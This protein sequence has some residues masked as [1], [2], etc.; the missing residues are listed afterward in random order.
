MHIPPLLLRKGETLLCLYTLGA[1]R[2]ELL[3]RLIK[4]KCVSFSRPLE[5]LDSWFNLFAIH[6]DRNRTDPHK[7]NDSIAQII[8]PWM[9]LVVCGRDHESLTEINQHAAGFRYIQPGSTIRTGIT[10]DESPRKH[11]LIL[12]ISGKESRIKALPLKTVRPL[13]LDRFVWEGKKLDGTPTV[14]DKDFHEQ[15]KAAVNKV[16]LAL[17]RLFLCSSN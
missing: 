15:L 10:A 9:D 7:T 5:N 13:A 2:Q 8:E 11:M 4:E 12:E 3:E 14:D 16:S 1:V 6:Q 17:W